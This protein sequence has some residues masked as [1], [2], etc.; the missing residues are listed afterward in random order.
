M[1]IVELKQKVQTYRQ[2]LKEKSGSTCMFS[3]SGP[4]NMEL[5]DSLVRTIEAQERR[6]A[7]LERNRGLA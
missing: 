3:E 7:E 4:V 2:D 1:N 5:I 6:I